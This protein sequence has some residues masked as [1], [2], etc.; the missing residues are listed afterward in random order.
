MLSFPSFSDPLFSIIFNIFLPRALLF[1]ESSFSLHAVPFFSVQSQFFLL[2][3]YFL[4]FFYLF[5]PFPSHF[6]CS[7]F[8]FHLLFL[9]SSF[10]MFCFNSVLPITITLR[11]FLAVLPD[12]LTHSPTLPSFQYLRTICTLRLF[13]PTPYYLPLTSPVSHLLSP[14]SCSAC[15]ILFT[16]MLFF[17]LSSSFQKKSHVFWTFLFYQHNSNVS[18]AFANSVFDLC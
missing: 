18:S 9:P 7:T 14:V 8:P 6:T 17:V 11:C 10:S 5:F 16:C 1:L 3:L 15:S 12:F 13:F 2:V 4:Y